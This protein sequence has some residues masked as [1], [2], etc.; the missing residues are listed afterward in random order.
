[1]RRWP[2]C[3]H[4][5]CRH[6]LGNLL[7]RVMA[8][9]H[10]GCNSVSQRRQL[11]RHHFRV[12]IRRLVNFCCRRQRRT[13]GRRGTPVRRLPELLFRRYNR[14]E[15]LIILGGILNRRTSASWTLVAGQ[16]IITWSGCWARITSFQTVVDILVHLSGI[17]HLTCRRLSILSDGLGYQF[18]QIVQLFWAR[19]LL[20][21]VTVHGGRRR[22]RIWQ[23]TVNELA[24]A[25]LAQVAQSLF[26]CSVVCTTSY[27]KPSNIMHQN[28][29]YV[30]TSL[31]LR[32][33]EALGVT[34][35]NWRREDLTLNW[36][37]ISSRTKELISNKWLKTCCIDKHIDTD[38]QTALLKTYKLTTLSLV[39]ISHI[40]LH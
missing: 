1:M 12:N 33:T 37:S 30:I 26:V 14:L 4:V 35:W 17:Q 28:T 31:N 18:I 36:G 24:C 2:R 6:S 10:H 3:R 9:L 29:K 39:K 7:Q 16:R 23:S 19:C 8:Y 34:H 5:L 25:S 22:W 20:C 32:P 38:K 21:R 27:R 11:C 13:R 40:S 15:V